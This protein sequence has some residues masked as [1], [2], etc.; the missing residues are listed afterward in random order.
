MMDRVTVAVGNMIRDSIVPEPPYALRVAE[1]AGRT[2]LLVE[3]TGGGRWY[4]VNPSKPEFYV[5]RGA[6]TM[7]ARLEEI[8]GGF[9]HQ[10]VLRPW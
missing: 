9:G 5:R 1:L 10:Q 7:P 8:A 2:L 6:S 4:A 3:V